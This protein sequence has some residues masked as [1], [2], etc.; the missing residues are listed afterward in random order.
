MHDK[1][2][3]EEKEN[4]TDKQVKELKDAWP[5]S[6]T[7]GMRP[8]P[9]ACCGSTEVSYN[10]YMVGPNNVSACCTKCSAKGPRAET[11]FDAINN[12]NNT[13]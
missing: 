8:C 1:D 11:L 13:V 5:E 9:F 4:L 6:N 3:P 2:W 10:L 12:W 7:I